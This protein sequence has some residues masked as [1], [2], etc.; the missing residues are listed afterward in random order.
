MKRNDEN[1]TGFVK[2]GYLDKKGTTT[3]KLNQMP[4]GQDIGNQKN[5]DIKD[6]P[7]KKVTP[8]GYE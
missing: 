6:L 4:G 7:M 1:S 5:A 2:S 8:L 3:T